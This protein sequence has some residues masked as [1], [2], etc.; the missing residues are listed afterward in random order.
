MD[1]RVESGGEI[2]TLFLT[3]CKEAGGAL[4]DLLLELFLT[5]CCWGLP[6]PPSCC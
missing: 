3:M 2:P 5:S 1:R 6:N 4:T